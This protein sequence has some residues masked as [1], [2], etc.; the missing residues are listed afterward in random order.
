VTYP[1]FSYHPDYH[2]P[3]TINQQFN[4]FRTFQFKG[5]VG[6]KTGAVTSVFIKCILS[7]L[8][9]HALNSVAIT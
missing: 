2:K 1:S 3:V 9:T 6:K 5:N 8:V 7:H 4:Y